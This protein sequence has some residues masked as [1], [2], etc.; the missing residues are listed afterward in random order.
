MALRIL[1]PAPPRT[2]GFGAVAGGALM[3]ILAGF[4]GPAALVGLAALCCGIALLDAGETGRVGRRQIAL[5]LVSFGGVIGMW[6]LVVTILLAML[7]LA[8]EATVL[9]LLAAGILAVGAALSLFRY[10]SARRAE[11]AAPDRRRRAA[12]ARRRRS[13][14]AA[15]EELDRLAG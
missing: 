4:Q 7:G 10:A 14:T 3:T 6:G 5:F 11:P 9:T 12:S 1:E 2:V 8:P 13:R 15:P